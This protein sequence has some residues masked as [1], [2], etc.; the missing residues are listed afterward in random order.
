VLIH[1]LMVE[2]RDR[3]TFKLDGHLRA[4][5]WQLNKLARP[6]TLLAICIEV[7]DE[8]AALALRQ[9]VDSRYAARNR[10]DQAF[11]VPAGLI[12]MEK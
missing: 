9:T 11:G 12:S 3:S 1:I 4:L 8:M 7:E 2:T 5:T 10:Q 6:D